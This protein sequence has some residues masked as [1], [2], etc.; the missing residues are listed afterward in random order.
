MRHIETQTLVH[1]LSLA[2]GPVWDDRERVL[3][4]V[5][6]TDQ[7]V[8]RLDP[9][10]GSLRRFPMPAQVASLG[11][12][13]SGRL[14]LALRTGIHLFDPATGQLDFLVNPEPVPATNRM[15][16]GK[17]GPDGAFWVGS[18]DDRPKRAAV[19]A[20]FRITP[21]GSCTRIVDGL[22]CSNGL[23]WSPDGRTMYHAD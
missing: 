18:L 8:L 14:V 11:L 20:L 16:D 9:G 4:F 22:F 21:E 1:P 10:S 15:N 5:D 3:W 17:V 23:A 13:A 12:A 6:I 7:Q 19:A 2:E